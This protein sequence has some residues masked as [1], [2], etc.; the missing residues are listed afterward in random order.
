MSCCRS[1]DQK[2]P[3]RSSC[4]VVFKLVFGCKWNPFL[5]FYRMH[6]CKAGRSRIALIETGVGSPESHEFLLF[7]LCLL[8]KC[9]NRWWC[10]KQG[11]SHTSVRELG[12]SSSEFFPCPQ[13][14]WLSSS[15]GHWHVPP[16]QESTWG[17]DQDSTNGDQEDIWTC[18]V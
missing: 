12:P 1:W 11:K 4:S 6:R 8:E 17:R 3:P 16:K 2:Y 5:K 15:P 13:P 18:L 7:P 10:G 9:R 14:S